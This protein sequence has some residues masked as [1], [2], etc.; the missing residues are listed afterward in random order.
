MQGG[1]LRVGVSAD[2]IPR[3]RQTPAWWGEAPELRI[4][5]RNAPRLARRK[6]EQR[7]YVRRAATDPALISF[8]GYGTSWDQRLGASLAVAHYLVGVSQGP[9]KNSFVVREPASAKPTARQALA[10]PILASN[11]ARPIFG[12]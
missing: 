6:Y 1:L 9:C 4:G 7:Q 5:F 3:R 12:Q 8:F 10:P 11:F 2:R